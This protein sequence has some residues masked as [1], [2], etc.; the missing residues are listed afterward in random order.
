MKKTR[1]G[2][3]KAKIKSTARKAALARLQGHTSVASMLER[4][5]D[6]LVSEAEREGWGDQAFAAEVRGTEMGARL[7]SQKRRG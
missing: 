2:P 6:R 4:Q 3:R 5:N 7:Y 1:R